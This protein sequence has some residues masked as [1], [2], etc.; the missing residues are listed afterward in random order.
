M[1]QNMKPKHLIRSATCSFDIFKEMRSVA[2]RVKA[3]K[4]LFPSTVTKDKNEITAKH[5]EMSEKHMYMC[6]TVSL[7]FAYI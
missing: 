1:N 4:A 3:K 7:C 5:T 6:D 2:F